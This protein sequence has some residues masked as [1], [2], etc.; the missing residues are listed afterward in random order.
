MN[1]SI[2]FLFAFMM[3]LFEKRL[4]KN[5]IILFTIFLVSS[6]IF[7]QKTKNIIKDIL[8]KNLRIES[9]LVF[10]DVDYKIKDSIYVRVWAQI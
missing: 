4:R 6:S 3:F 1:S 5:L 8:N 7:Y 9:S 10:N 2:S